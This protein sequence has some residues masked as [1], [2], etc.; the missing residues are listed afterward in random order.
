MPTFH[1]KAWSDFSQLYLFG[2]DLHEPMVPGHP[3]AEWFNSMFSM[4]IPERD[5][6][7]FVRESHDPLA[8]FLRDWEEVLEHISYPLSELRREIFENEMG[9]LLRDSGGLVL[10]N[11]VSQLN[12][13]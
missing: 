6:V 3:L 8:I 7:V 13:V 10:S 5:E 9:V 11:V 12:V 1:L 4:S 2:R